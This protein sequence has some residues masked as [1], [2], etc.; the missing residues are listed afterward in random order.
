MERRQ[1]LQPL[2][3][4]LGLGGGGERARAGKRRRRAAPQ[5]ALE[6]LAELA[7][8]EAVEDRV[9][10]AVGVSQAHAHGERVHRAQEVLL[11]ERHRLEL[12]EDAPGGERLVGQSTQ[13]EGQDHDGH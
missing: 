6:R 13:E 3:L 11:A 1:G 9:E 2:I 8:H 7:A 10:A 12:D 4:R 5:Q